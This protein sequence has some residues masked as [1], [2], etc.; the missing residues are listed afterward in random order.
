MSDRRGSFW[1]EVAAKMERREKVPEGV[2]HCPN[3]HKLGWRGARTICE[4]HTCEY[5]QVRE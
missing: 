3:G 1:S 2:P 5:G 4:D